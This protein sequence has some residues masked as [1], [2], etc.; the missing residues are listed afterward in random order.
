MS[1]IENKVEELETEVSEANG[2]DAPT[3]N[4]VKGEPMKKV[5][6]AGYED[7][8][9]ETTDNPE[10]KIDNAKKLKKTLLLQLKV[11]GLLKLHHTLRVPQK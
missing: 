8:G 7:V 11:L 5:D 3:K 1:E 9:G 10:G 6:G 4:S 2:Q